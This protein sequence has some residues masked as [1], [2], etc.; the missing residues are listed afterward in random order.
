M[1]GDTTQVQVRKTY[2][3][4][5]PAGSVIFDEGDPGDVLFVIQAGE[6]ELTRLSQGV[7]QAVARLGDGDFFGE[8]SVIVAEVRRVRAVAVS[9]CR[10]LEIDGETLEAMCMERP[11]VAIRIIRRLTDRVMESERRLAALGLDDLLRPVVRALV[12]TAVPDS[13]GFRIPANLR[14]V[15][16]EAGLSMLEAHRALHQLLDQK[17]IRFVDDVLVTPDVDRLSACLDAPH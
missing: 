8:M 14:G 10:L 17:L 1:S 5:F 3:R 15:A 4:C 6:V 16:A 11:E 7:R 13:G 2:E 9:E 12:K